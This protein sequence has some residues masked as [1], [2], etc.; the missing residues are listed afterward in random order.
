MLR[1]LC[2]NVV[3]GRL[4]VWFRNLACRLVLLQRPEEPALLREAAGSLWTHGPDWDGIAAEL[5]RRADAL[6]TG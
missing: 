2:P 5:V 6:E 3:D 1:E 4:P